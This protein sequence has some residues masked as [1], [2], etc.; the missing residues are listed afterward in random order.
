ML[1]KVY[2]LC[3]N[4]CLVLGWTLTL[5][6]LIREILESEN[7]QDVYQKCESPLKIS[8]TLAVLEIVH[9]SVGLVRSSPFT[10]FVQVIVVTFNIFNRL[11]INP[12]L[13]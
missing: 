11:Y 13:I 9:A 7:Y 10:T 4:S 8:Q 1:G 6:K 5:Y 3:Y 12:S 2:L